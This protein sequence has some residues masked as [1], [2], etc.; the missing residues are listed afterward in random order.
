MLPYVSAF[1]AVLKLLNLIIFFIVVAYMAL[2][3]LDELGISHFR[4]FMLAQD[5]NKIIKV[6]QTAN[7]CI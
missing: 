4:K 1:D 5:L 3:R 2:F 6:C 7:K